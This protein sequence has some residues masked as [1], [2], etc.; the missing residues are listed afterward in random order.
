MALR[1]K[2]Q[3]IK[4]QNSEQWYVNLPTARY[5]RGELRGQLIE[6]R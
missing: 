2:V 4:R 3:R 1:T 5:P 6:R